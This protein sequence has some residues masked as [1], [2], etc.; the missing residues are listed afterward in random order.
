MSQY[1]DD[2][3]MDAA[4]SAAQS[5]KVSQE[6]DDESL[7][8]GSEESKHV[9]R[10]FFLPVCR[11]FLFFSIFPDSFKPSPR[12]KGVRLHDLKAWDNENL[13]DFN[14]YC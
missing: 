3:D 11:I 9:S 14:L 1:S 4:T 2:V 8:S 7:A 10:W 6:S 13:E 5:K 12:K